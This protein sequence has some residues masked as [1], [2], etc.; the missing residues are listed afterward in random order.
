MFAVCFPTV[1]DKGEVFAM[2]LVLAHSKGD[3][4]SNCCKL[5]LCPVGKNIRRAQ[6]AK[7]TENYLFD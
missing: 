5:E 7:R 6:S 2:R 3:V 4:Q 1:H